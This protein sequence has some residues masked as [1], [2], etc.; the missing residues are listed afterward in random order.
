MARWIATWSGQ[1]HPQ[2]L[3]EPLKRVG[4]KGEGRFEPISWEQAISE[5]AER[6]QR[7]IAT[8]GPEAVLPYSYAGTM[9]VLQ[10]DGMASRFFNRMGA[11]ELAQTICSEAGVEGFKY[12][13]G[14]NTG[15]EPQDFAH[16][17]LILLWGTNTLTSNM[18]LWP[19]VQQARKQGAR[20]IVIDPARTRTA[21]AA[22]EWLPIRPGTDGALALAMMH[23]IIN[24]NLTDK[25]YVEKHTV[26]FSR[27]A[28]RVQQFGPNWAAQ[29]T[30]IPAER[31]ASLAREYATIQ[32]CAIRLNYGLQRH[33]GGGMAVR[34]IAILPA[35]VGAWRQ[36]GGGAML[37]A[38][39]AFHV[40]KTTLERPDLRQFPARSINM[41]RLGDALSLDP[42]QLAR[43]HHHPRP[44]D[45][46][47]SPTTAG[48]PI[49]VLFV[50]NSNPAAVAPDQSAVLEGLQRDDL[51]TV[52]L[53]HFQTDT[54][55]YADYLLPATTQLEHWDILKP[56]GH[57]YMALNQPGH[58]P[59]RASPCPIARFSAAWPRRW[60]TLMPA[61]GKRMRKS[62]ENSS[63]AKTTPAWMASPGSACWQRV[64]C[65]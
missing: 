27:L 50:F 57:L 54:A 15:I 36:R 23:V 55:D 3:V 64:S 2:R 20:V 63:P 60:A 32:P 44:I 29:I 61:S 6:L 22:D 8:Y 56:Y 38:S 13:N 34:N 12:T 28:E 31:I 59:H 33:A 52:V 24:E 35:L 7:I 49:K 21:K 14:R 4:A 51:F 41:I 25:E 5:I 40:D 11:S 19:F 47:P 17:R 30:G 18:H 65:V 58:R 42:E 43:A 9:G 53:E 46:V 16:A 26:G 45:P 62:C 37:S 1:Y 39:G 10:G 48:P